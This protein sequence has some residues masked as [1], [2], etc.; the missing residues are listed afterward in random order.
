M[1][2]NNT[3]GQQ[4]RLDAL[5]EVLEAIIQNSSGDEIDLNIWRMQSWT[6]PTHLS[7]TIMV[8]DGDSLDTF[9]SAQ[10]NDLKSALD[11]LIANAHK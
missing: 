7:Y 8:R 11:N 2:D 6:D 3:D 9:V 5:C 1:T 10:A 4:D